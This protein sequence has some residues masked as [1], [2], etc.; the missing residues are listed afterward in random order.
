MGWV[1]VIGPCACCGRLFEFNAHLVPSMTVDGIEK[2]ICRRCIRRANTTR[3]ANGLA[4]LVP[5]PGA[6]DA[7][8]V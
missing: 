5:L 6:Y 3:I 7:E 1:I 8:E 4:P 2:P